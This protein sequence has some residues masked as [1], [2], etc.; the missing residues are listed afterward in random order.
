[1]RKYGIEVP[2]KG[3]FI[4]MLISKWCKSCKLL[5]TILEQFRDDGRIELKE[6][7][8]LENGNLAKEFNIHAIPALI[9]FKDGTLLDE[10]IIMYG[11][12]II[13][14]GILIGSFNE[15]ILKE[16]MSQI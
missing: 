2:K 3:I 15:I 7:D 13:K 12:S 11:E 14:K 5:S 4:I 9:F 1:M 16:I 10:D 8:I 6:L